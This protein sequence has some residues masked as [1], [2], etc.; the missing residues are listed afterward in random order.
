MMS[1]AVPTAITPKKKQNLTFIKKFDIIYIENE[2]KK[3]ENKNVQ[4]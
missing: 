3:G 4:L 2:I 1:V